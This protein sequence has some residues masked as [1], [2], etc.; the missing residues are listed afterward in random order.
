MNEQENKNMPQHPW[1]D[2]YPDYANW[3]LQIEPASVFQFFD[4]SVA[5]FSDHVAIDFLG[6][7][8]SYQK[9]SNLIDEW[10]TRARCS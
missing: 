10:T 5:K 6:Y 9:L 2:S 3:N 1:I 8:F 4:E 7:E